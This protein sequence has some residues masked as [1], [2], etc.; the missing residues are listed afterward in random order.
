MALK[1]GAG[2]G[3]AA[4]EVCPCGECDMRTMVCP[5]CDQRVFECEFE[6]TRCVDDAVAKVVLKYYEWRG[7]CDTCSFNHM[8]W[9]NMADGIVD[10]NET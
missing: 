6:P 7:C 1:G 3:Q 10:E 8:H 2:Q 5:M 9:K 4:E